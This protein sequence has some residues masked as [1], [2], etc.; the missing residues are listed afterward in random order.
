MWDDRFVDHGIVLALLQALHLKPARLTC[1]QRGWSGTCK[2]STLVRRCTGCG[3]AVLPMNVGFFLVAIRRHRRELLLHHED[4]KAVRDIHRIGAWSCQARGA[5][6]W[7][8]GRVKGRWHSPGKRDQHCQ[9]RA[10]WRVNRRR[11]WSRPDRPTTKQHCEQPA[12]AK[13]V[14]ASQLTGRAPPG[15]A[16][17]TSGVH[18][19]EF[20]C[21]M[22]CQPWR[23]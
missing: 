11:C 10:T 19:V 15:G 22:G 21:A 18:S 4:E 16:E 23:G 8:R 7:Q 20:T 3:C 9:L 6:G 1:L 17:F 13:S 5:H 2:A 12:K 14:A